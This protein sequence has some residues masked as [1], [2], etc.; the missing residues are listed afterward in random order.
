M[1]EIHLRPPKAFKFAQVLVLFNKDMTKL[2]EDTPYHYFS[3][4]HALYAFQCSH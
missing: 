1:K 4:T 3:K 2:M